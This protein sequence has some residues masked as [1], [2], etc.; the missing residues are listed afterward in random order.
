MRHSRKFTIF[1]TLA[2]SVCIVGGTL[3]TS[4]AQTDDTSL[5]LQSLAG[6]YLLLQN[7]RFQRLVTITA[8]HNF[9]SVSQETLVFGFTDGQ[10]PWKRSGRREI[11]SRILDFDFNV[12]D[13][14]D[15][16]F[17]TPTSITRVDFMMRFDENFQRVTW[18]FRGATFRL[19]QDP[20]DPQADPIGRF[21][22]TFTGRRVTLD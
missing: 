4:Q 12:S 6:T 20:L 2:L 5:F 16:P 1:T 17:G 8:D 13:A 3:R 15:I 22:G 9:F 7:N 19:G 10:G 14:D 11:T 21:N 18:T